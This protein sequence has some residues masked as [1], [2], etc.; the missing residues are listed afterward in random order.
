MI[1]IARVGQIETF[2]DDENPGPIG[3]NPEYLEDITRRLGRV[4]VAMYE[5]IPAAYMVTDSTLLDDTTD[6]GDGA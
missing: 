6:D 3:Y 2:I 4:A 5:D 1:L